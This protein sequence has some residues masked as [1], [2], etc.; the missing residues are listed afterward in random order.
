[1]KHQYMTEDSKTK[2]YLSVVRKFSKA[3][4]EEIC[5]R[6]ERAKIRKRIIFAARVLKY[7]VPTVISAILYNR[8]ADRLSLDR[9]SV[10][11]GSETVVVAIVWLAVFVMF[12]W[13]L[14]GDEK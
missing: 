13:L 8:L 5:N 7:A 2:V 3:E 6:K 9:G 1:M 12:S 11:F 14:G 4:Y 10:E